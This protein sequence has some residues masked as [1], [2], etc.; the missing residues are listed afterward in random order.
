MSTNY[1]IFLNENSSNCT[2]NFTMFLS[3]FL[4]PMTR[5]KNTSLSIRQIKVK[6]AKNVNNF[7]DLF[8]EKFKYVKKN[9]QIECLQTF[10][11]F[12]IKNSSNQR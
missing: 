2:F 3:T 10:T 8:R 9:R 11:I 5:R 4:A 12:Q 7:Y 6:S 1:H